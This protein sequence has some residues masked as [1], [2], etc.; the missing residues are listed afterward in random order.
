MNFTSNDT[1]TN[2]LVFIIA[3]VVIFQSFDAIDFYFQSQALNK[4]VA[5]ANVFSLGILS[6]MFGVFLVF[7]IEALGKGCLL[8]ATIDSE[9]YLFCMRKNSYV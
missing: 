2:A 1:Y 5:C 4:Y 6:L 9:V 8:I 7:V 3:S